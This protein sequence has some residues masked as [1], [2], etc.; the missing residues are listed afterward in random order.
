ME[1]KMPS[2]FDSFDADVAANEGY[3]YTT[4]AS[5]SSTLANGRLTEA[6]LAMADLRGKRVIDIGC[7]DGA[8]SLELLERG[9]AA[10]IVGIDPAQAAVETARRR[11]RGKPATFD[12]ARADKLAYDSNSFDVAHLR[13]VLHHMD[14][15][16]EGLKEAFRVARQ[17]IVIEPNGYNPVLKLIEKVSPYHREHRERSFAPALLDKWI[18]ALGGQV[19]SRAFAGLVPFFCPAWL[20]RGLKAMEPG[21]EFLPG[22]RALSCAVYVFSATRAAV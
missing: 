6:T 2:E 13:G 14:N 4:N 7:G 18:A 16:Q 9:G 1:V 3:L 10:S 19:T 21:V 12:V 8:Y 11:T 17:V 5:L 22:V 15:P 20:A